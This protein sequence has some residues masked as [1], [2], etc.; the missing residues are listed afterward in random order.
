MN[1]GNNHKPFLRH[2]A[3]LAPFFLLLFV[4]GC[5]RTSTNNNANGN[6]A[7]SNTAAATTPGGNSSDSTGDQNAAHREPSLVSL[8]AGALVVKKPREFDDKWS[9]IWLLDEKPDTGWSTPKGT[10]SVQEIVIA[11]PELTQLKRLTFDTGSVDGNDGRAAKDIVVEMS[12]SSENEGFHRVAEV[13]L[14]DKADNQEFSVN[15]E[16][17]GRWVRLTIKNNHGSAEYIELMDFRATGTQLTHTPFPDVSGTYATSYNDFHIKQEGTSITGCYEYKQGVLE[18]GA[19]GRVLAFTWRQ[20]NGGGPA[21]LVFAPDGK[22]MTGVWW[23][24]SNPQDRGLWYGTRKSDSIGSCAHWA[25]SIQGQITKDVEEFGRARVYGINFDTDSDHIKDESKPTLDKIVS[26]LKVKPD[27]KI[28]IEGHTDSTS[29]PQ[30]NQNLS[31]RRAASVKNYLQSAGIDVSRVKTVGY[32]ATK[33]VA[34]NDTE[35]GRAQN[36]RV[37]LTK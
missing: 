5:A 29:T 3:S 21:I 22:Q 34:S 7:P 15:A 13:S 17:A 12:N 36:R 8:S 9:A 20:T 19:D 10:V 31:E 27:W 26:M 35:M 16:V 28:T 37:E 32:G 4:V 30:H 23:F 25:G 14:Q 6:G 11:L 18:G 33:P 1:M 2:F 24:E